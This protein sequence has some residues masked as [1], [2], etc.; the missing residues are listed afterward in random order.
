MKRSNIKFMRSRSKR[1]LPLLTIYLKTVKLHHFGKDP[2]H[3]V[4]SACEQ[5]HVYVEITCYICKGKKDE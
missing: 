2:S 5:V 3:L 4:L 1:S